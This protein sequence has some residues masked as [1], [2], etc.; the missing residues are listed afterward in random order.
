MFI[1]APD[2][3]I[4]HP[5]LTVLLAENAT[6][7]ERPF[8]VAAQYYYQTSESLLSTL[9]LN[10]SNTASAYDD[11][12]QSLAL[13]GAIMTTDCYQN[14]FCF[15]HERKRSLSFLNRKEHRVHFRA[16]SCKEM[17]SL[18]NTLLVWNFTRSHKRNHG[19]TKTEI[20][21]P[22][23]VTFGMQVP[24]CLLNFN[25]IHGMAIF[26]GLLNLHCIFS[27]PMHIS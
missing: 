6:N 1:W 15:Q 5:F 17:T 13:S 16:L 23:A 18:K 25:D 10:E 19:R 2:I 7:Q 20:A 12:Q 14:W 8:A 24:S 4:R 9:T 26:F 21:E 22:L 27:T 11:W 3:T